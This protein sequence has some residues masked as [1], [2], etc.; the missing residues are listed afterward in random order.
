MVEKSTDIG[1]NR[2]RDPPRSARWSRC[3]PIEGRATH[4]R[5]MEAPSCSARS[6]SRPIEG[7]AGHFRRPDA[8]SCT[9]RSRGRPAAGSGLVK[10]T[11]PETGGRGAPLAGFRIVAVEQYGAGPFGT[12]MLADL[13]ADVIK[14]EDPTSG[15]DVS[16]Y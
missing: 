5:P 2:G 4:V 12:L 11:A 1:T 10:G 9:N 6:R 3:R 15:G 13:G 14:V 7:S 16:R 8:P